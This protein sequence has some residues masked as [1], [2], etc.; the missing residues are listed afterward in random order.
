MELANLS[1]GGGGIYNI[2]IRANSESGAL[3]G[4]GNF[5]DAET[6]DQQSNTLVQLNLPA[7]M[8]INSLFVL[9]VSDPKNLKPRPL[10]KTVTFKTE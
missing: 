8:R 4:K 2:E 9:F 3:L 1:K 7:D 5:K 10:L 6:M